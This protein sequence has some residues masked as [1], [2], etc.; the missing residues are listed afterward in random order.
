[1]QS[2]CVR[3]HSPLQSRS[4]WPQ[5]HVREPT[6]P[7]PCTSHHFLPKRLGGKR[8]RR[9]EDC[10]RV[11]SHCVPLQ[12]QRIALQPHCIS[13]PM[14]PSQLHC[15]RI[16]LKWHGIALQSHCIAIALRCIVS[17]CNQISLQAHCIATA[18]HC[19]AVQQHCTALHCNRIIPPP[20]F[21]APSP[22]GRTHLSSTSPFT[23]SSLLTPGPWGKRRRREEDGQR[24]QSHCI[25]LH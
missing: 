2:H 10:Q 24:V 22:R 7:L 21:V 15:N 4:E 13:R 23:V 19:I 3:N 18:V 12:S 9:E 17:H 11:Q 6:S 20:S 5:A 8:R 1:M 14:A 16:A 25:A